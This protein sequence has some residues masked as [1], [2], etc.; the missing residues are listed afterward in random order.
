[1]HSF[2]KMK[3]KLLFFLFL[4]YG[5]FFHGQSC[6]T[7]TYPSNGATD[8]PVEATLTWPKVDGISTFVISLGTTPNGVDILNRRTSNPIDFYTPP[9]GLPENTQIYV[10][11]ILIR[12]GAPAIVCPPQ[13]FT[14]IDVTTPPACT[15]LN[16]PAANETNVDSNTEISWNYAPTATGYRLSIGTMAGG[17][18][19]VDDMDVGNVLS[20]N[21][22]E[23]LLI[24]SRTYVRIVP[25]NENGDSVPCVEES[26]TTG[27]AT[28]ACEPFF[29]DALGRLVTIKP[30][31]RFPNQIGICE[32]RGP[33][34]ISSPDSADGF[35]WFKIN[36][37]NSETL[38]SDAIE[39]SLSEKGRYR[40]VAYNNISQSDQI[41][42]CSASKE[43]FVVASNRA[44]IT[45]IEVTKLLGI[46]Q[47]EVKTNGVGNYEYA[48]DDIDGPYQDNN[49]FIDVQRGSHKVYVRDKNGCGIVNGV[50]ERDLTEEDFPKFFTPNG[51][52]INDFWQY[53]PPKE[54]GEIIIETI[55]IYDRYGNFLVQ[56]DPTS[57]GWDGKFM[58]SPLPSSDYWF[59][60]IGQNN[61][62][63]LGHFTLKR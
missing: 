52:N 18:D 35:R 40:Y 50:A 31:I 63:I 23:D 43:F 61:V 49:I 29:D 10:S 34:L 32:D 24:N 19:I 8:I 3:K 9:L 21:P 58:G 33:S 30:Q 57:R 36:E 37:D 45:S 46:R 41:I 55:Q 59:K 5:C 60:A 13:T 42:E 44:F 15:S 22:P 62:K 12:D 14:T 47:I 16:V 53:I 27:M 6:P 7:L 2:S 4:I 17:A 51:D 1:M 28:N 39:V 25:Y 11:I 26:F 54:S 20:Y 48:I 56:V 38:L